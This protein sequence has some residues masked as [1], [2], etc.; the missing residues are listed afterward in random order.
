MKIKTVEELLISYNKISSFKGTTDFFSKDDCILAMK[1]YA[2][3]FI[4]L[5][6]EE[7]KASINHGSTL[8]ILNNIKKQIK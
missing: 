1:E 3:Q 2:E 7:F 8:S 6:I 5:A 4:E